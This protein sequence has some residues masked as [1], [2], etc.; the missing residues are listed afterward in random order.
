MFSTSTG[1]FPALREPPLDLRLHLLRAAE[2][3]ASG[4]LVLVV[5]ALTGGAVQPQFLGRVAHQSAPTSV[6]IGG[7]VRRIE[8]PDGFSAL[9]EGVD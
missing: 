1:R 3:V 5:E 2:Q 6:A 8:L 9:G 4:V 7:G